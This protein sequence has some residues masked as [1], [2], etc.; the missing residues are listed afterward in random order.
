M[1]SG[2][3][4]VDD[5]PYASGVT[6]VKPIAEASNDFKPPCRSGEAQKPDIRRSDAD[7]VAASAF[8]GFGDR[9][10]AESAQTL[11]DAQETLPAPPPRVR[12]APAPDAT[13][14]S[15]TALEDEL[16]PLDSNEDGMV[17]FVE[18][19]RSQ[20]DGADP[21]AQDGCTD[22]NRTASVASGEQAFG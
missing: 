20:A 17:S 5:T 22:K 9:F 8:E 12:A 6:E 19:L 21:T 14:G 11:L 13:R 3:A 15:D 10:S 4:V 18:W 16:S 7:P 2:V 1:I